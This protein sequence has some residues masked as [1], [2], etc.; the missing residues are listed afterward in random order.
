MLPF[1]KPGSFPTWSLN[2]LL[3]GKIANDELKDRIVLVGSTAPSLRDTFHTPFTRFHSGQAL[4]EMPGVEVHAHRVAA[5]LQAQQ[6]AAGGIGVLPAV[7]E[8]AL[9]LLI[10]ALGLGLGEG[11]RSLQRSGW[12]LLMAEVVLLAGGLVLLVGGLWVD[13]PSLMLT[14]GFI[15]IAGWLRRGAIGQLQRRQMDRLLGQATSP[16]IA[17]ELWRQRDS[18]LERGSFPGRSL[19]VTVLFADVVGFSAVAERFTAAETLHWLNQGM[20]RFVT[21]VIES[22]GMVNK[23]TGDGFLAVFGVPVPQEPTKSASQAIHCAACLQ[24][25]VQELAETLRQQGSPELKLRV[26]LHSGE[27]IAGSMGSSERMEF[28]VI[29]DVV[30][31]C[32]RLEALEKERMPSSC[33]VLLSNQTKELLPQAQQVKLLSWGVLPVKGRSQPVAVYELERPSQRTGN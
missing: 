18:L 28:A 3:E 26:G 32:A 12:L 7:W 29:G 17:Q 15:T 2:D 22:G 1:H 33:R 6:G 16:A 10:G 4:A 9:L 23:F 14:L 31:V 21:A 13:V 30:N 8:P 24:D 27:V 20:E 25:V 11:I 5:L 19:Q